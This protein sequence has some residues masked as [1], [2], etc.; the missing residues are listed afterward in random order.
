MIFS[1]DVFQGSISLVPDLFVPHHRVK[2]IDRRSS[3]DW[4]LRKYAKQQ[5]IL[6]FIYFPDLG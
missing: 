3:L 1:L 2:T 4:S 5:I 6:C